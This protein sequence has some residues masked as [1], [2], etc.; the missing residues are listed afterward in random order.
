MG[1]HGN[2]TPLIT[3][4]VGNYSVGPNNWYMF[5]IINSFQLGGCLYFQLLTQVGIWKL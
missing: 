1:S 5:R 3:V 2:L 4:S